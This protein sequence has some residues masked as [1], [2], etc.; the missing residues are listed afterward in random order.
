V[1][2]F[3]QGPQSVVQGPHVFMRRA[4]GLVEGKFAVYEGAHTLLDS[5]NAVEEGSLALGHGMKH[6][7]GF[8]VLLAD[9]GVELCES[10]F[11][12]PVPSRSSRII[13]SLCSPEGMLRNPAIIV[14]FRSPKPDRISPFRSAL[15]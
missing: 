11:V 2:G 14:A 1:D 4:H 15:S 7:L 10:L 13:W 5:P 3:V 12:E 8:Q 9:A 6:L